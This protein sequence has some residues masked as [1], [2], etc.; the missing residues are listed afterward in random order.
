MA[1]MRLN[2]IG[3]AGSEQRYTAD[4]ARLERMQGTRFAQD[5]PEREASALQDLC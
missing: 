2:G 1:R 3:L 4:W 5:G